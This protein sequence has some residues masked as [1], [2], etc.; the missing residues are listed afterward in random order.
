MLGDLP[1]GP[2]AI[3]D[4]DGYY[5]ASALADKLLDAGRMVHFITS[6]GIVAPWTEFTGEQDSIHR[7]L[8]AKGAHCHFNKELIRFAPGRLEV[9]CLYGGT[10]IVLDVPTLIPVTSR[11]PR[12]DL[13]VALVSDPGDLKSVTRIGDAD[14]PGTIAHAV[15]AGHRFARLL[16][17]ATGILSV[18]RDR[19]LGLSVAVS[20]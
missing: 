10:A 16:G 17:T 3:Y 11:A 12:D 8:L 1:D 13:H 18:K 2:I 9:G 4:D 14:A 15:Y 19:G 6:A 5:L 20:P 7:R